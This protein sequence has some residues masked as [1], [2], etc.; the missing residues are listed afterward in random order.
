M[1]PERQKAERLL[2]RERVRSRG[3]QR[4]RMVLGRWGQ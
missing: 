3:K 2:L 4:R 1:D